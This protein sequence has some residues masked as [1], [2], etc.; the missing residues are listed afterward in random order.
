MCSRAE[1]PEI[2]WMW[3][4]CLKR[5]MFSM[6]RWRADVGRNSEQEIGEHITRWLELW[7]PSGRWW[8]VIKEFWGREN[9][10][11]Q[12]VGR[13]S[14][15]GSLPVLPWVRREGGQSNTMNKSWPGPHKKVEYNRLESLSSFLK[16]KIYL[17]FKQYYAW[18]YAHKPKECTR[19]HYRCLWKLN[20]GPLEE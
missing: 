12:R 17:L 8:K 13:S 15:G 1:W 16:K 6:G 5:K 2:D 20:L 7:A 3:K 11:F 14:T 4:E 19:S 9:N 10:R 18:I